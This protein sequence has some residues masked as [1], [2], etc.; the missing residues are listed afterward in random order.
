MV[1]VGSYL[2]VYVG[3]ILHRFAWLPFWQHLL[4][5]RSVSKEIIMFVDEMDITKSSAISASVCV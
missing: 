1:S 3:E 4:K 5:H 2:Y